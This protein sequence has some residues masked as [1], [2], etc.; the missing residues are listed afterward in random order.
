[1]TMK[2]HYSTLLLLAACS[3][4]ALANSPYINKVHEYVPAPGQF[5]HT[6]FSYYEEGD[7]Y[8]DILTKVNT[9]LTEN[10][11]VTLGA[12]GGYVVVGFDHT[13]VNVAGEYDFKIYGN[14]AP[15]NSEPGIVMVSAD[16]NGDGLPND[17]WYELAGSEFGNKSIY[18]DYRITYYRP[19]PIGGDVRWTDSNGD[20]GYVPRV[21]AH[22]QAS[23]YPQWVSDNTLTFEG[24]RLPG[25]VVNTGSDEKPYWSLMAY[26]WGY[27]DNQPNTGE[28]SNF[29]IEWAIKKDLTPANL[30]GIDFI[31]IHTGVV[32]VCG[33]LGE[34]STEVG[35]I[36]DLHPDAPVSAENVEPSGFAVYPNP[37]GEQF[38]TTSPNEATVTVYNLLGHCVLTQPI[39]AGNTEVD[40]SHLPN[41]YYTIRI[42]STGKSAAFKA[43]KR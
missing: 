26:D 2:K 34:T 17:E 37:F 4:A 39:N 38:A 36:E 7:T 8:A 20:E 19:T 23:Y 25:N 28:Y 33:E 22:T 31:K 14:A 11:L 10:K 29:N 1:M 9:A 30:K 41:G 18:Y 24:T 12:F 27:A 15:N 6:P 16:A 32:Q 21:P 43:V 42:D 5:I 13:I 35:G 40:T 3:I